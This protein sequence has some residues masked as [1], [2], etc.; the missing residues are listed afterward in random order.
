M[1]EHGVGLW[2]GLVVVLVGLF[3]V[4]VLNENDAAALGGSAL[5]VFGAMAGALSFNE[6]PKKDD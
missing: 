2:V 6:P 5:I 3:L 4:V 1:R